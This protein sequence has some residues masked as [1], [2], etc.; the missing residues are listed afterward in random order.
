MKSILRSKI[1]WGVIIA[2]VLIRIA[3]PYVILPGLNNYL[4]TFSPVYSG[5]VERLGLSFLRGAYSFHGFELRLKDKSNERFFLAN[6]VDI[7]LAFRELFKGRITTDIEI[8]RADI[9]LTIRVIDAIKK[10]PKETVAETQAAAKKLFPV[11]IERLDL[12]NSSFE[13]AELIAIPE[14]KRWRVTQM[15]GRISNVTPNESTPLMFLTLNGML[16]ESANIK[17]V[18]QVN[19]QAEPLAW[20]ADLEVRAFELKNANEWFKRKA[21]LTFTSGTLDIYGEARSLPDGMEGYVKPFLKNADVV[22]EKEAFSSFKHFGIEVTLAAANLILR[23]SKEK[24][25]ATKVLFDYRNGNFNVNSAK[26]INEAIKN[27]F[28]KMLAPGID[29]EIGLKTDTKLGVRK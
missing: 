18:A 5:H 13:F 11:R 16:F 12:R 1:L 27:G 6:K 29:D 10:A 17:M 28:S 7:S 9:V 15:D 19:Q 3:A 21:S 24:T 4:A 20:D 14:P 8:D 26:A 25:M 2:L 22:A 23:T